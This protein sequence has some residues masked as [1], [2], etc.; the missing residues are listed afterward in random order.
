MRSAAFWDWFDDY[1]APKLQVRESTFRRV[2][3]YLDAIDGPVTIVETGCTRSPDNW[4]GDGQSSMLFDHYLRF[5]HP[6]SLA[7]AVDID[8]ETTALCKTLVSERIN[9]HT[10][11]S[12]A[13]L[14]RLAR[15]LRTA[16]R[17]VNLLYL[18][19]YDI[20]WNYPTPS[21]IHHLK[22]LV[23]IVSAIDARTLVV[24]DDAPQT[25]RAI[26]NDAGKLVTIANPVIGGKG[27]YV[28]EYAAQVGARPYFAHYQ[29]A[30]TGLV[31]E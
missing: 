18:D 4:S 30:W 19:S 21:A 22:E 3:D 15:E 16:G 13:V 12:V 6:Q 14:S 11:D 17:T 29:A 27:L 31:P 9:V 5:G 8:A 1:A 20:D 26:T 25:V 24:V 28:A 10:G 7:H 23:S 2:F